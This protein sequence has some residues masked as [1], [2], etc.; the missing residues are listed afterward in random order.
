MKTKKNK[1]FPVVNTEFPI[2]SVVNPEFP[3]DSRG[4]LVG[5]VVNTV[6]TKYLFVVKQQLIF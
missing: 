3:V 5:Q 2:V 1:E 6:F 4:N